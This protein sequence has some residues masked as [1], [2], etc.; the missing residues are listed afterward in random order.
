MKNKFVL[1]GV[2]ASF[3]LALVAC[4]QGPGESTGTERSS[5]GSQALTV[6]QNC[7]Q[8]AQT[9]AQSATTPAAIATCAQ[10]LRACLSALCSDA[11]LPPIPPVPPVAFDAGSVPPI[12]IDAAIPPV[13]IP[14][15]PDASVPPVVIPPVAL[16]D[17][18]VLSAVSACIQDLETCLSSSTDPATCATQVATCLKNAI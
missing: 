15:L 14:P 6:V 16:P 18:A 9:C 4:S 8:Q 10:D 3:A 1:A 12:D 11:G 5:D 7:Q 2:F 13:T 17:A